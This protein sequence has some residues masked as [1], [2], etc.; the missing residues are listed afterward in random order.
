MAITTSTTTTTTTTTTS[1]R[2]EEPDRKGCVANFIGSGK[3]EMI[4][5]LVVGGAMLYTCTYTY[6]VLQYETILYNNICYTIL[7]YNDG[8]TAKRRSFSASLITHPDS[9]ASVFSQSVHV[10]T[11]TDELTPRILQVSVKT[12]LLR[13]PWPCNPA[14]ETAI[15]PQI[16]FF[17]S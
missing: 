8:Q 7:Y 3:F 16:W 4:T 17:Q 13:E 15:R 10:D 5:L 9:G 12:H 1:M 2:R 11:S 14:A 6:E